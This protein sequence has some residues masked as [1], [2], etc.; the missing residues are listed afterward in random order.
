MLS[1]ASH[2]EGES[3]SGRRPL[4]V[5]LNPGCSDCLAVSK[6]VCLGQLETLNYYRTILTTIDVSLRV[7][8]VCVYPLMDWR[9]TTSPICYIMFATDVTNGKTEIIM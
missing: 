9:L 5:C 4:C 7:N 3:C 2:L 8:V 1:S 6:H